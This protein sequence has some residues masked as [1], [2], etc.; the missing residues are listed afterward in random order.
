[1]GGT[2]CGFTLVELLVSTAVLG[3]LLV[4]LAQVANVV[5]KTWGDSQGRAERR[6]QGRALVDFI[7]R[8]LRGAA[9]PVSTGTPGS[10]PNLQFVLNPATV[11]A[12]DCN[13]SALFW[14][15]PVGTTTTVGDM[16]VLGYF[17]RWDDSAPTPRA[18]LCR[19]FLNPGD[20]NHRIYLPGFV[21]SWV[22]SEVLDAAAPGTRASSYRG[23]FAEN[24][25]GFW[26]KCLDVKGNVVSNV[27]NNGFSSRLD[28]SG[29]D[30]I[31][32]VVTHKAPA[33][34]T[35]MEVSIVLLDSRAASRVTS[36]MQQALAQAVKNSGDA[37]SCIRELQANA[38]FKPIVQGA[39]A[40][41]LRVYL[42]N[43]P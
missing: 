39:T 27:A 19:L 28:Y 42:E 1:M 7:A 24:V 20:P 26:A 18:A 37:D 31:D 35:S 40:H 13:P 6:Q 25:I 33:L 15:A 29:R 10:A 17:V 21:D 32:A 14:Q 36:P 12:R 3:L 38:F 9:L 2:G 41:K 22:D 34:P 16:A 43:G 8:D 4:F 5:A 30:G 11:A 23:L